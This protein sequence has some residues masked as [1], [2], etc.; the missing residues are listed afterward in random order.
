MGGTVTIEDV[1]R[2]KILMTWR[3]GV[4]DRFRPTVS[5]YARAWSHCG[6]FERYE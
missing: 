5:K 6:E 2:I 4:M 3:L 1:A